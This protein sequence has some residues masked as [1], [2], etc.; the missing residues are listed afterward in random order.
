VLAL[1]RDDVDVQ[2][3]ARFRIEFGERY[4]ERVDDAAYWVTLAFADGTSPP[5]LPWQR[6]LAVGDEYQVYGGVVPPG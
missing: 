5:P 3:D 2:V 4:T 1:V 6:V